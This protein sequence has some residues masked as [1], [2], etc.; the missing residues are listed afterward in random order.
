MIL[1]W[2]HLKKRCG[3]LLSMACRGRE[4]RRQ[5]ERELLGLLWEGRVD[6][7]IAMLQSRREQMKAPDRLDELIKY[8]SARQPYIPNYRERQSAGL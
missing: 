7:A 6:E 5:L 3:E 1:C 8:L 4:H 2:Y